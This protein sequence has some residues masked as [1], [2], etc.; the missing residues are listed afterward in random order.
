[1]LI[2]KNGKEKKK[3]RKKK[4]ILALP[5]PEVGPHHAFELH[6]LIQTSP[7][8]QI[9]KELNL[10]EKCLVFFFFFFILIVFRACFIV[11]RAHVRCKRLI[12]ILL[13]YITASFLWWFPRLTYST[14]L[15]NLYKY[16]VNAVKVHIRSNKSVIRQFTFWTCFI[17]QTI[18][19]SE[20]QKSQG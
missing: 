13:H 4:C 11:L 10:L 12:N 18:L 14:Y 2:T 5:W 3:W 7:T 1:M 19:M 6:V 17:S 8:P 9:M 15:W 16:P 20:L